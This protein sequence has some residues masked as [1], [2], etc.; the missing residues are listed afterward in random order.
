MEI[1]FF[2]TILL[3]GEKYTHTTKATIL[4]KPKGQ[5]DKI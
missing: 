1:L 5:L 3:K 2:L 4:L